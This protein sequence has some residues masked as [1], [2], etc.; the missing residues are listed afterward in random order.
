MEEI[1]KEFIEGKTIRKKRNIGQVK[2]FSLIKVKAVNNYNND[3][4]YPVP[5]APPMYSLI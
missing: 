1:K 2:K 5:S 3:E 4:Q